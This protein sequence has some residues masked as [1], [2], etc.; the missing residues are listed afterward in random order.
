MDTTELN[1]KPHKSVIFPDTKH[2]TS[3]THSRPHSSSENIQ[4]D[5]ME[6]AQIKDL[7]T[8]PQRSANIITSAHQSPQPHSPQ[9]TPPPQIHIPSDICTIDSHAPIRQNNSLLLLADVC[10]QENAKFIDSNMLSPEV[11][12]I[13]DEDESSSDASTVVL[14]PESIQINDDLS[15]I[16]IPPNSSTN[17]EPPPYNP[18]SPKMPS[19]T[20]MDTPPINF[21]EVNKINMKDCYVHLNDCSKTKSKKKTRKNK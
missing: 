6:T 18:P 7:N 3:G 12:I 14:P 9:S 10:E 8:L 20:R 4:P 13:V 16:V 11:N 17:S 1:H 21:K 15:T 2:H 19:L 5:S